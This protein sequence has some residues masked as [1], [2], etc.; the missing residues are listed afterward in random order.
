MKLRFRPIIKGDWRTYFP[1]DED[2]I[3]E[4]AKDTGWIIED[5]LVAKQWLGYELFGE[6]YKTSTEN[7]SRL[8]LF[9]P[10]KSLLTL[11]QILHVPSFI[12]TVTVKLILLLDYIPPDT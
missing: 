10:A 11:P 9:Y 1:G 7:L 12:L 5:A 6:D 8:I 3:A 2:L 4:A